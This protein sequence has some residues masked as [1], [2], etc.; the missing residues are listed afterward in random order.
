MKI[1]KLTFDEKAKKDILNLY[2]KTLDDE[3]YLV[4]KE[5]LKQRVTE[6]SNGDVS[7]TRS[8][9]PIKLVFY[10]AFASKIKALFSRSAFICL[11]MESV[12]SLGGSMAFSSTR[13]TLTPHLSVASSRTLRS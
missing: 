8:F 3:D 5:N 2:G 7:A 11:D 1:S 13:V 4:E 10:A 12:M 6:H 9:R